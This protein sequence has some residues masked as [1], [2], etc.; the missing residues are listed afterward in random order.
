VVF[1]VDVHDGGASADNLLISMGWNS[2]KRMFAPGQLPINR[3]SDGT[4]N[5]AIFQHECAQEFLINLFQN[6]IKRR[7]LKKNV[8]IFRQLY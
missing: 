6:G 1:R 4:I 5:P 8:D 7:E 2:K 3:W